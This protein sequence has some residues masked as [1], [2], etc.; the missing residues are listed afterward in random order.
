MASLEDKITDLS[1]RWYKYVNLDHHKDRDCHFYIEKRWSYGESPKYRAYHDGYRAE[2]WAGEWR[3]T[4]HEA[5][6]DLASFLQ[7]EIDAAIRV[8][9]SDLE[10][11]AEDDWYTPGQMQ[12]ELDALT[13]GRTES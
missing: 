5:H 2:H 6:Y 12:A 7:E 11:P 8:L 13:D 1:A 3:N 4:P 9:K 10:S